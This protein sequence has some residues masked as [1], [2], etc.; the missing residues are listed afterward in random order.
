MHSFFVW[1]IPENY[2]S[3]VYQVL[4]SYSSFFLVIVKLHLIIRM[5]HSLFIHPPADGHLG[6]FPCLHFMNKAATKIVEQMCA[7][8][9]AFLSGKYLEAE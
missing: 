5:E 2:V 1:H 9:C 4:C 7:N 8:M 3:E 6:C